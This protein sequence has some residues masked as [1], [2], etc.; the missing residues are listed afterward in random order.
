MLEGGELVFD[1]KYEVEMSADIRKKI[2][3]LQYYVRGGVNGK[4]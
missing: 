3:K 4:N 2:G 1:K